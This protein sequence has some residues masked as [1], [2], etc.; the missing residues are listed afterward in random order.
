MKSWFEKGALSAV[1]ESCNSLGL[2]HTSA[3]LE[4]VKAKLVN[5]PGMSRSG[6]AKRVMSA[7]PGVRSVSAKS[8]SIKHQLK[9]S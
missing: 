3:L 2:Q 7:K 1:R 6:A 4:T 8:V 9:V 5:K